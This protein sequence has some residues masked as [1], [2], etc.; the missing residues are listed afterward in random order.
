MQSFMFSVPQKGI[1][2]SQ[3]YC[4][5]LSI[6]VP[7]CHVSCLSF[8]S[9]CYHQQSENG[10]RERWYILLP[11]TAPLLNALWYIPWGRILQQVKIVISLF[12]V[13][14]H[15]YL[16][17]MCPHASI[18]FLLLFLVHKLGCGTSPYFSTHSS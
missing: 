7:V 13:D 9:C 6:A 3:R 8:F 14:D 11:T 2:A 16:M 5:C 10:V 17:K 4:L 15:L 12:E 18:K 1:S